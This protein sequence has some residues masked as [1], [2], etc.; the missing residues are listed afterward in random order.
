[1]VW[2]WGQAA[3]GQR[4][5][6]VLA[7]LEAAWLAAFVWFVPP[8]L[9][10]GL[11]AWV[12]VA[13]SAFIAT[14]GGVALYAYRRVVRGHAAL[15]RDAADG[16]AGDLVWLAPALIVVMTVLWTFGGTLARPEA[17][18]ARYLRDWRAGDAAD[19]ASVF[20]SAPSAGQLNGAW[21][22]QLPRLRNELVQLAAGAGDDTGIDPDQPFDSI[23]FVD[24]EPI[25]AGSASPGGATGANTAEARVVGVE[26]VRHETAH[27]TFFGLFPTTSDVL[28]PIAD[29]GSITLRPVVHPSGRAGVPDSPVWLIGGIDLLGERIGS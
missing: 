23:R 20:A 9:D 14:W 7:A 13:A 11:I 28:V 15:G 27:G 1:M 5:A 10:G 29:L 18:L 16:G 24:R 8:L 21:A 12:F 19:A 22:R 6:L 3:T 4:A 17:T 2:G 26:I 25:P